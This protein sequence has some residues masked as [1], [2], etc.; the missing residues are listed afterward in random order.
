MERVI[1]RSLLYGVLTWSV[2]VVN[3]SFKDSAQFWACV[4]GHPS[5]NQAVPTLPFLFAVIALAGLAAS[6]TQRVEGASTP[7]NPTN[8]PRSRPSDVRDGARDQPKAVA[9]R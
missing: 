3:H 9:V 1:L 7:S 4:E 8:G 6:A 5:P 2:I